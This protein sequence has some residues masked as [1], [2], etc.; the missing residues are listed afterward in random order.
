MCQQARQP[1]FNHTAVCDVC[2]TVVSLNEPAPETY[3]C[4]LCLKG[5]T[6][7]AM[8]RKHGKTTFSQKG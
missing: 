4:N 1:L 5:W 2:I 6:V 7:Q 3:V 8:R